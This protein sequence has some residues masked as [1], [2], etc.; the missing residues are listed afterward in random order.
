MGNAMTDLDRRIDDI[1]AIR[2]MMER[3]SKFLSLSGL[4]G[5]SAGCVALAGAWAADR[6][7]VSGAPAGSVAGYLILDAA[8]V[9][10]ASLGLVL[11]FSRR[12]ARRKGIALWGSAAKYVAL[13]LAGPLLT[14]GALCVILYARDLSGLIPACTLVFYGLALLNAGNFTFGEVRILGAVEVLLGLCA[15]AIPGSALLVWG[16]GFGVCHIL[17]GII[18]FRKYER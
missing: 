13:A 14:G 10:L 16:A 1:G 8:L 6:I 11:Y 17:Y 15:A 3:A 7:L 18:H 9:L 2:A 4:S 5:I 12:L